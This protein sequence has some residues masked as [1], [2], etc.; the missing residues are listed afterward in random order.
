MPYPQRRLNCT[1]VV[2]KH[3]WLV[4][5]RC[6]RICNRLPMSLS[7]W[8]ISKRNETQQSVNRVNYSWYVQYICL[9]YSS[10]FL[11][12]LTQSSSGY[13]KPHFPGCFGPRTFLSYIGLDMLP[14]NAF[15]SLL[16]SILGYSTG[17]PGFA[18]DSFWGVWRRGLTENL[19]GNN[20][21]FISLT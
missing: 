20:S 8:P 19:V 17:S 21:G 6:L 7:C 11:G 3:G 4:I 13:A 10:Y 14:S 15:M 9:D 16:D 1:T 12:F 18:T 5:S 2:V